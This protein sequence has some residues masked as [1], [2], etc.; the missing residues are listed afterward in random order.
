M[1]E[2]GNKIKIQVGVV[3]GDLSCNGQ[4]C[5]VIK[6]GDNSIQYKIKCNNDS[7]L[8]SS[9]LSEDPD[10]NTKSARVMC[11]NNYCWARPNNNATPLYVTCNNIDSNLSCQEVSE[12]ELKVTKDMSQTAVDTM[13]ILKALV[14]RDEVNRKNAMAMFVQM[15]RDVILEAQNI[16][17]QGGVESEEAEAERLRKLGGAYAELEK[18]VKIIDVL[19]AS[20]GKGDYTPLSILQAQFEL[21]EEMEDTLLTMLNKVGE[22]M[23]ILHS[24]R[25]MRFAVDPPPPNTSGGRKSKRKST[26]RKSTKR[27]PTKP[28]KPTKRKPTKRK[29]AKR[30][31]T[32]RRG[33]KLARKTKKYRR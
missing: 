11:F 32:K 31:H 13:D 18:M 24:V 22:E 2:V 33:R 21:V 10:T 3:E 12:E 19:R 25:D 14:A 26:K 23:A 17:N 1:S 27:K 6:D 4:N 29:T 20:E 15:A 16:V 9:V 8:E 5:T 30:K 7:C 28:T